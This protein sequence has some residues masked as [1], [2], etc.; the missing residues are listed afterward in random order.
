MATTVTTWLTRFLFEEEGEGGGGVKEF[1]KHI[2]H[3]EDLKPEQ[4][5]KLLTTWGVNPHA[6]KVTE[7]MDGFFLAFG[8]DESGF[9]LQTKNALW[10]SEDDINKVFFLA[11]MR[12]F[13]SLLK[14][15]PLREIA[16]RQFNLTTLP[17]NVR[18]SGECIPSPD[19]NIIQYDPSKVGDGVMVLYQVTVNDSEQFSKKK[20]LQGFGKE[21]E[22]HTTVRFFGNPEVDL[23]A[24][25]VPTEL[26]VDLQALIS[27]HGSVLSKA[28][29]TPEA[30]QIK[31]D[32]SDY[33]KQL[34]TKIKADILAVPYD[35]AF[36][37][38]TEGYVIH[39]PDGSMV[40]IVDKNKFTSLKGLNWFFM[41]ELQKAE[42]KFKQTIKA[43]PDNLGGALEVW[44]STINHVEDDYRA[45]GEQKISI[46]KKRWETEESIKLARGIASE[47]LRMVKSG[48]PTAKILEL[49]TQ[50]KIVPTTLSE[51]FSLLQEGGHAVAGV[52]SVVPKEHL[53]STVENALKM[54]GLG[55]IDYHVVGNKNKP[56]LGDVDVAINSKELVDAWK[57]S[58]DDP[59]KFWKD[60]DAVLGLLPGSPSYKVN[61]GFSQF[62][63]LVPLVNN[64][65]THLD[66]VTLPN[67]NVEVGNPGFVQVDFFLGDVAWM[68]DVMSGAPPS[69]QHKAVYR[70]LLLYSIVKNLPVK[71]PTTTKYAL[72]FRDGVKLVRFEKVPSKKIGAPDKENVLD[73]KVVFNSADAL[74]K[75]LFGDDIP[76][77]KVSSYEEMLDA[78]NSPGFKYPEKIE[79]I[80]G[81]FSKAVA[82][83]KIAPP[84]MEGVGN[85]GVTTVG[86]FPGGFKPFHSG[87]WGAVVK[88][89]SEVDKLLVFTALGTSRKKAKAG[90]ESFDVGAEQLAAYWK[91]FIIPVLP[92]NV[93]VEFVEKNPMSRAFDTLKEH[94]LNPDSTDTYVFFVG[95]D[96]AQ[97]YYHTLTRM[98]PPEFVQN[99]VK[100][101]MLPR[102]AS[103][104]AAR[105]TLAT[106]DFESFKKFVP[107]PLKNKSAEIFNLLRSSTPT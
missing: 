40:K 19:H 21:L 98:L 59:D 74:S 56:L 68:R 30:K 60:V 83:Q 95:E 44:L 17:S 81:T 37:G 50:R 77:S 106:N 24:Y 48:E 4:L 97:A 3:I 87:H 76:F 12:R 104:T 25:E 55:N 66:A 70:N 20:E 78:M 1:G 105:Q 13:F 47:M 52:N 102:V 73:R 71:D 31:Q 10:R 88:A 84:L 34:G 8:E 72:N 90:V 7:K 45:T 16:Q 22:A 75:F 43:S 36:G 53:E 67:G 54:I 82:D 61:K 85:E 32:V 29:K 79:Q 41:D 93:T 14:G 91:E 9:Y 69:S 100:L 86:L 89:A 99:R 101:G 6:M 46:K 38:D 28:A 23:S 58:S 5:L 94:S 51:S 62:H 2:I 107:A 57:L 49:Y 27:K 80:L 64:Q 39:L 92:G 42:Q 26:V 65:G 63:V 103:G 33:I 35:P 15:I 18:V 11:D 96:D